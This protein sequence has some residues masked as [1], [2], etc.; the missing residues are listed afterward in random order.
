MEPD[1]T[2]ELNPLRSSQSTATGKGHITPEAQTL[3]AFFFVCFRRILYSA[4]I[5]TWRP[6]VELHT[7]SARINVP[8]KC[9]KVPQT[10]LFSPHNFI[11]WNNR[12]LQGLKGGCLTAK[13]SQ[14]RS[15]D[16]LRNRSVGGGGGCALSQLFFPQFKKHTLG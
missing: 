2:G 8:L 11:L 6:N 12:G 16:W 9:L 1:C 7:Y 4:H 14:V 15:P 5:A 10:L 13:M 3:R